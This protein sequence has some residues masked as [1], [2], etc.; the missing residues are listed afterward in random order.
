M[1]NRSTE[2]GPGLAHLLQ[3]GNEDLQLSQEARRIASDDGVRRN[4]VRDDGAGPHLR[5]S[6]DGDAGQD[7]GADA[8]VA[9]RFQTHRRET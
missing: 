2:G 9:A 5:P 8:D 7:D 3:R 6:S 4:I 1:R